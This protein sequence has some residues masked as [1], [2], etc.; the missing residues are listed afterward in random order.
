MMDPEKDP[1]ALDKQMNDFV[2]RLREAAGANLES[3]ILFGS[4]VTGDFHSEFSN[5]NLFCVV[6]DTSFSGDAGARACS[7][8]VERQ[9]AAA[10]SVHDAG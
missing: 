1:M 10:S 6:R 3:V 9:K 4:S 7:E 2:G 5:V 8:M